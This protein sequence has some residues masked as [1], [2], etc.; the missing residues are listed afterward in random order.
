MRH[1]PTVGSRWCY[2]VTEADYASA[3]G[4]L[5][6]RTAANNLC[7]LGFTMDSIDGCESRLMDGRQA[8][9]NRIEPS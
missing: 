4:A 5:Y 6:D 7:S 1:V 9:V 2:G 3:Y 8:F